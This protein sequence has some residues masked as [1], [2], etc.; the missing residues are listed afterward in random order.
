[1]TSELFRSRASC[2]GRN[3]EEPAGKVKPRGH[4]KLGPW[5]GSKAAGPAPQRACLPCRPALGRSLTERTG[6]SS[7]GGQCWP[8]SHRRGPRGAEAAGQAPAGGGGPGMGSQ[9]ILPLG[10]PPSPALPS[11]AW[12]GE[13]E[14][15]P[16]ALAGKRGW[17]EHGGVAPAPRP[18]QSVRL[19]A[20]TAGETVV[21]GTAV[22]PS[23]RRQPLPRPV[24]Q[25]AL[26]CM[27]GLAPPSAQPPRAPAPS[28]CH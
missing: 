17:A 21:L 14:G 10:T 11:S 4:C 6:R 18:V 27:L 8:A 22:T 13:A 24:V 1:M 19:G 26:L 3:E 15:L 20:P 2:R 12:A 7:P 16:R 23:T 28:P 5:A 25:Q 9:S